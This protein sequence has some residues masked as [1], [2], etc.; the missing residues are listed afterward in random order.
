M[1]LFGLIQLAVYTVL[2]EP[3]FTCNYS[4]TCYC[5]YSEIR[6]PL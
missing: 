5:G 1:E 4:Q 6:T 3:W 2:V